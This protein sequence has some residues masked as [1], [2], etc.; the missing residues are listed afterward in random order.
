M[1]NSTALSSNVKQAAFCSKDTIQ[2]RNLQTGEPGPV[3]EGHTK[4]VTG[5]AYSPCGQ[6]IASISED[7]TVRLWD[8]RSIEQAHI[9][10]TINCGDGY[11]VS[12]V[13]F[14]PTGLQIAVGDMNGTVNV[15]DTQLRKLLATTTLKGVVLIGP[16]VFGESESSDGGGAVSVDLIWGTNI[17]VLGAFGMVLQGVVGLNAT[18]R[19]LLIQRDAIDDS[20]T[21]QEYEVDADSSGY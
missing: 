11:G 8:L 5:L 14:S 6:W 13:T 16:F 3:L 19:K 18:S 20:L 7:K 2:L 1:T 12:N 21:Y 17:G 10:A 15:Y 9:L 4:D